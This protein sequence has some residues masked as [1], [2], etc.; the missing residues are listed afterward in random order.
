MF[1]RYDGQEKRE[2]CKNMSVCNMRGRVKI[3]FKYVRKLFG[4]CF[5]FIDTW[6]LKYQPN[7]RLQMKKKI[8]IVLDF[9]W[10]S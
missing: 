9:D 1:A 6:R 5:Y 3:L 10:V 7:C 4:Y 2:A 8:M